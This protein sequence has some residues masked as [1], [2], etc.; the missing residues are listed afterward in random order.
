MGR[1]SL[2]RLANLLTT[3]GVL[4]IL[5]PVTPAVI[6]EAK[7]RLVKPRAIEEVEVDRDWQIVIPKIGAQAEVIA[8]VS[9]ANE[10]EY[11]EALK[12]GVAHARGSVKPG[13]QGT[14]FLFAHS[15]DSILNVKNYN[16]VFYLLNKLDVGDEVW[17]DYLGE[18]LVYEVVYKE[19]VAADDER[20]VK[21]FQQALKGAKEGFSTPGVEN[22]GLLGNSSQLILQTCWP[23]GTT[24]KRLLIRAEL[25]R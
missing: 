24:W 1:K 7:F 17:V 3:L 21:V 18:R 13:E 16:A 23:P 19:V 9:S 14:T 11:L 25:V 8:E 22:E 15:T 4:L 12:R 5:I 10:E 2:I 6:E 20:Y